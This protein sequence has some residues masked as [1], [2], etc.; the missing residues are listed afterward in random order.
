MDQIQI[1]GVNPGPLAYSVKLYTIK[2]LGHTVRWTCNLS[3][4]EPGPGYCFILWVITYAKIQESHSDLTEM[5]YV[6]LS[7]QW[8][9]YNEMASG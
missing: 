8:H 5:F 9:S 1:W 3:V 4:V 2:L 6:I 7:S